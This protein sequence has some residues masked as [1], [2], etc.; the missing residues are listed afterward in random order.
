VNSHHR[1]I[2]MRRGLIPTNTA[3]GPAHRILEEQLPDDWDAQQVYDNHQVMMRHGKEVRTWRARHCRRYAVLDLCSHG[4]GPSAC[5]QFLRRYLTKHLHEE[6]DKQLDA[7]A[8]SSG[9][10]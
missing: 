5:G 3:V 9:L 4:E 10:D 2:A 8:R 1:R 7:C 6:P